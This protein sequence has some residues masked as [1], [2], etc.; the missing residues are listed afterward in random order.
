MKRSSR[1][2]EGTIEA[3]RS[4]AKKEKKEGWISH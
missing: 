3:A 1:I 4:L 2:T